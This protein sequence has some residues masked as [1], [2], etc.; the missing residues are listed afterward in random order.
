MIL[1]ASEE[2]PSGRIEI[3]AKI[4]DSPGFGKR[5]RIV[6]LWRSFAGVMKIIFIKFLKSRSE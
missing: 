6:Y 5:V 2:K 4:I 3:S 1:M